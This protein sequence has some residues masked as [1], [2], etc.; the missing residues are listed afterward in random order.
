[1]I[2][3]NKNLILTTETQRRRGENKFKKS[4]CLSASV[5]FSCLLLLA[6]LLTLTQSYAD[7]LPYTIKNITDGA[8]VDFHPDFS[9][10]GKE[11]VFASKSEI[12]K[13]DKE[14]WNISPYYVNL[15]LI[16]SNGNNRRPLTS[17]KVIDCY[18]S[19]TPDGEKVL[20]VSNRGGQWDIWSIKRDGSN[21]T[22]LTD[23]QDKDY[24]PRATRDGKHILFFST[25][26]YSEA[27]YITESVWIM[28]MD[29]KNAKR[30]S[31]GG[32]GDWYP[33][34]HPDGKEIIF[35]SMRL[36]GGSLWTIDREGR[37]YKRL[38]Y[39]RVLE[40][41]PNWSPDG[42]KISY[43]SRREH[44][45]FDTVGDV[46]D[47]PLEIWVMDRDGS[48]KRQLTKNISGGIWDS[49]FNLRKPLDFISYYH[50][51]WHPDG[52]KL[53][54]TTW[55]KEQ[56]G[57]YISIIEFDKDALNRLPALNEEPL[58]QYTLIG[59]REIT[60]G[61]W[62]DFSPSFSPD[63]NT[64]V[65]SSNRTGNWDVWSI[66]ADGENLSQITKGDDDELA[67][68]YSPDGKEIAFLKK[69]EPLNLSTSDSFDIWI[70]KS[71]GGGMRKITKNIPILSYPIWH[72]DGKEIAFVSK[73]DDGIGI[74][75]Y[76]INRRSSK[77]VSIIWNGRLEGQSLPEQR[78]TAGGKGKY[79]PF[80][81]LF[82]YKI[83]YNKDGDRLTFE[84]NLSGNVEIWV[85][86]SDG[87]NMSKITK[88][89]EPHWNPV[90]SPDGKMVAYATEKFA[91]NLGP[92]FWPSSNY[93]IWL[94]DVSTGKEEALTAEEQTDWS[95][96]WSPD[97]KKIAYVTNRSGEFKH[98]SIWLLYLK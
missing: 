3:M 27:G 6:C 84:S 10:D 29:G 32:K 82:L 63:G 28:D 60:K 62:E 54:L 56:K 69:T 30:L 87:S 73:G 41:F 51:S 70:M 24:S 94:A 97:G 15:W 61:E 66:G 23:N 96:V 92:P 80:K 13:D 64:I 98:N 75:K 50:L 21:L 52:T 37:D 58:L 38:T 77:K 19:F 79:Y 95:P 4:L 34:M 25:P 78:Q 36:I 76:D 83:D 12:G 68:V 20:F 88:G 40:F 9:P 57:S 44:A 89:S 72:P 1:M 5:A 18:P 71:D 26:T 48:N 86:N 85:M 8:Q 53:A 49:R 2:K 11:L 43:I 17:G 74:W 65:F 90:F 45:S 91:S 16:D 14:F 33:S 46:K 55:E 81:E 47:D 67:P 39:G 93:N 59:E 35:A 31:S 7:E 22:R 42:E